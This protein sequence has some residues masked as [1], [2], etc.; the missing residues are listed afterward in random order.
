MLA[1]LEAMLKYQLVLETLVTV[2]R[3]SSQQDLLSLM[4]LQAE[5]LLFMP[6]Q[7]S[8]R[9]DPWASLVVTLC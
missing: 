9:M 7:E 8:M 2:V 1:V 4:D 6:D 5:R 3:S